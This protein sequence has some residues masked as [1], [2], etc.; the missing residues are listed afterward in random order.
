MGRKG[1][2]SNHQWRQDGQGK[3]AS[4]PHRDR[5]HYERSLEYARRSAYDANIIQQKRDAEA[6][7]QRKRLVFPH[8]NY[9]L[10]EAVRDGSNKDQR[11]LTNQHAVEEIRQRY[12]QHW[13]AQIRKV[14]IGAHLR[15]AQLELQHQ[16]CQFF[17]MLMRQ[18][19]FLNR[20]NRLNCDEV[21]KTD[22]AGAL[23]RDKPAVT[24]GVRIATLSSLCIRSVAQ[25]L[26]QHAIGDVQYACNTLSAADAELLAIWCAVL[27]S[28]T[29]DY[30]GALQHEHATQMYFSA[31]TTDRGL[32][33]YAVNSQ[34]Q[35]LQ[36]MVCSLRSMEAEDC[37]EALAWEDVDFSTAR[38]ASANAVTAAVDEAADEHQQ[39][40]R[41][42][43]SVTFLGSLISPMAFSVLSWDR[44]DHLQR[45][46]LYEVHFDVSEATK[47]SD[48]SALQES[49]AAEMLE[50][51][52]QQHQQF[53][54]K[55]STVRCLAIL[56]QLS[57]CGRFPHLAS[58]E[59]HHCRWIDLQ[60][61][62]LWSNQIASRREAI[63]ASNTSNSCLCLSSLQYLEI[64]GVSI[65]RWL[66]DAEKGDAA[67]SS[68]SSGSSSNYGEYSTSLAAGYC[69]ERTAALFAKLRSAFRDRCG[70]MLDI[71]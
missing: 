51:E 33:E 21:A 64:S 4:A 45:L 59:L 8:L 29:D 5:W 13:L 3:G 55:D 27:N 71:S 14:Q 48:A 44:F 49:F 66:S 60:G 40:E 10:N 34:R 62:L 16:R 67:D 42:L 52:L 39:P 36:Q 65:L 37:W 19:H 38:V 20:E 70:V 9:L 56:S 15:E 68:N 41:C 18:H 57:K 30:C 22:S 32:R 43:K 63:T 12:N 11:I 54:A 69:D 23:G 17:D 61:L 7:K 46:V 1:K 28:S 47:C 2:N 6:L 31:A 35:Q 26:Q 24:E 58:V 53:Q 50:E 25:H